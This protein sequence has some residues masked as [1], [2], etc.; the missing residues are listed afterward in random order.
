M[1]IH[2]PFA[3]LAA[4]D[5]IDILSDI[6]RVLID[7]VEFLRKEEEEKNNNVLDLEQARRR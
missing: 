5:T 2:D 4:K 1:H 7:Q 6:E 3:Q